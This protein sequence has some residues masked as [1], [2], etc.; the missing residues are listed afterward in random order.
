MFSCVIPLSE[1]TIN[2]DAGSPG[3]TATAAPIPGMWTDVVADLGGTP[4]ACGSA[5]LVVPRPAQSQLILGLQGGLWSSLDNGGTWSPLGTGPGSAV[6]ANIPSALVFD[7]LDPTHYWEN[8]IYGDAGGVYFTSDNG[9]T[10]TQLGTVHHVD[11]VAIDFTDPLRQTLIAGGHEQ[12]QVLYKSS[13]GGMTWAGIGT[14]LP[15]MTNCTHPIVYDSMTY[16]VGC[17]GFGGGQSGVVRTTDGGNTWTLV[18]KFGGFMAPLQASDGSI[19]WASPVANVGVDSG[20]ARSIDNG[21]TWTDVVV[22][23]T[24]YD[25]SPT[26]LPD[27]RLAIIGPLYGSQSVMLSSD[28]GATWKPVTPYLPFSFPTGVIYSQQAKAFYVWHS[29]SCTDAGEPD[30]IV[31]FDFDYTKE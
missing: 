20:M 31:R 8:G 10:F 27:G 23:G 26:E 29:S 1:V 19:Y 14:M 3:S 9:T 4:L 25:M 28:H 22:S 5:A 15:N 12:S 30:S 2:A 16:V 17:G 13:D 6:I 24:I 18:T 21:L 11:L 7:P